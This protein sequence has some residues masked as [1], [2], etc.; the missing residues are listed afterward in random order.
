MDSRP[1][2]FVRIISGAVSSIASRELGEAF[3]DMRRSTALIQI[4]IIRL[5]GV[6]TDNELARFSDSTRNFIVAE[7]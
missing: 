2:F 7:F 5:L 3:N 4:R 1:K 6:I